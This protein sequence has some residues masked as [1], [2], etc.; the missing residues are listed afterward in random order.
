MGTRTSAHL[1]VWTPQY[2]FS[3]RRVTMQNSSNNKIGAKFL[4]VFTSAQSGSDTTQ[5]TISGSG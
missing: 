1:T 2:E 5:L 3:F 4:F